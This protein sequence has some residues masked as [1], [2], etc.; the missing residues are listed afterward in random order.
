METTAIATKSSV[1]V[2]LQITNLI[3]L[4]NFCKI[5]A[6]TEMVPKAYKGKPDDILVAMLHG[7][8]IGLP[9]LQ[10]LQSIAV[11]NGIPSVY[12]DAA[13][14]MVRASGKLEDFDEWIEV[15]GVRQAGSSFP[16]MKWA[17]EGKMIVAHCLSLRVG[18]KRPRITTYSADDAKRAKLWDK[19][20]VYPNGDVVESP[21]CTTP[22]R[23]L[24]F[25]SRSWNLRDE[26]GD[27]LKGMAIYEEA[28]DIE[29]EREPDGSY[30]P[31]LPT[32]EPA[33]AVKTIEGETNGSA[34]KAASV[35]DKMKP[36]EDQKKAEPKPEPTFTPSV[37]SPS[38]ISADLDAAWLSEV[39]DCEDFLRG[40]QQGKGTLKSIREGFKLTDGAY[41]MLPEDQA[42]YKA[43]LAMAVQ[44][45]QAK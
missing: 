34:K 13:L 28:R 12:G 42:Q 15:D 21:W 18:A 41:P 17:E 45:M 20:K 3:E 40:T 9:H 4:Q 37:Q 35:L 25:R 19:K 6:G 1:S 16:I 29:T 27:V 39:L 5:L 22:Q 36:K 2:S 10:A 24:M 30:R 38:P 8:E 23:M 43:M 11:V 32:V 26:F 44:R 14:A 33:P 7:Q 31:A